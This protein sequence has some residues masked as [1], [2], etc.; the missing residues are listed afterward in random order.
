MAQVPYGDGVPDVAP[1]TEAPD[2]Y[3]REQ[4]NPAEFGGLIAQGAEKA[5]A[6]A[7]QAGKFF[8]EAVADGGSNDYQ[9]YATNVVYG[10]PN[11]TVIGPDGKP[12]QDTG[13]MGLRGRAALDARPQ[14][15]QQLDDRL[16]EIRSTLQTPDQ[17]LQF[18]NFTRRYRSLID[19]EIGR[20]A[21][22]E[23]FKW[24]GDL[25]QS[26]ANLS[27]QQIAAAPD[28]PQA[29]AHSTSDLVNALVKNVQLQGGGDDQVRAAV[30]DGRAIALKTQLEAIGVHDPARAMT[31]L[32]LDGNRQIASR[33]NPHTG[34]SYYDD[35]S[36]QMRARADQQD[37]V[38]AAVGAVNEVAGTYQAT[39]LPKLQD[40]IF[41]QESGN[42]ANTQTSPTGAVGY[43]QIEPATFRQFAR[44]GEDINATV[45]N[46][47]V[48]QRILA[49]Y[50][51]Q[52]GGDPYRV[53]VAYYSGPGNV[54]PPGSP[55]PWIHDIS[56]DK[57]GNPI[58]SVSSY[59][60]DIA[61]RLGAAPQQAGVMPHAPLPDNDPYALNA[62]AMQRIMDNPKLSDNAREYAFQYLQRSFQHAQVAAEAD[63]KAKKDANDNA[64][65]GYVSS[66]MK[67]GA[68]PAMLTAIANDQNLTWETKENLQRIATAD[69][70]LESTTQFGKAY[71]DTYKRI[72][73]PPDDPNRIND[74]NDI[75]KLGI[76]GQDNGLT[77]RGVAELGKV[78][79][80]SRKDPD[81]TAVNQVKSSLINYAKQKL[82][83][84][85][86]TLFPGVSPLKDP[87][88]V[89]VFD[90][91]FVPKFE[92]AYDSWIKAGKNPWE[93]L[94]QDNVD[95]LMTGMRP[96]AQMAADRI[97]AEG[98]A[99]GEGLPAAPAPP[100][101]EGVAPEVWG[102]LLKNP[103]AMAT[104]AVATPKQY[105]DAIALLQ[106]NP[107]EDFKAKFNKWFGTKGAMAD[108]IL[109]KLNPKK[110]EAA[111][112][113]APIVV[114]PPVQSSA[115]VLPDN[116]IATEAQQRNAEAERLIREGRDRQGALAQI[117]RER[118]ARLAQ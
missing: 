59:V 91:Q 25:N 85:Q 68:N 45:D 9:S 4:A 6:G 107:T 22:E 75:L 84:D 83:F 38:T 8:G 62:A 51:Q 113:A 35:L 26:T 52:Y 1:R 71:A 20:H 46:K 41:G 88:G 77:P 92:A 66:M 44:P 61:H 50:Y 90:A 116:D 74:V 64:A 63:M 19:G 73:L 104:G 32:N 18:D 2:D 69:F 21:E 15:T 27:L 99:T 93:F 29:V 67:T 78:F 97:A 60:S 54:A 53:A 86:E 112:A 76:P 24:M 105:G 42:G 40:A 3:Q 79:M 36:D 47:A 95:K 14:I 55:T 39:P 102:D 98:Q 114:P 70:G 87:K 109:G 81:Q 82:S 13:F 48:G 10:D 101:P 7:L 111:P 57:N 16:K 65:N 89:Q 80:A 103:P 34:R 30:N 58:K 17:Q 94:T 37:G 100:P 72:F 115:A 23:S 11:K 117:T 110:S 43:G 56:R 5:G 33:V 118:Q 12:Q 28:N 106:Q 31:L 49:N 96:K 108:D